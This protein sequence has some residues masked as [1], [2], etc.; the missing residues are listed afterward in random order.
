LLHKILVF[1]SVKNTALLSGIK[2]PLSFAIF[3]SKAPKAFE[4]L[5]E[6]RAAGTASKCLK[7]Q[8]MEAASAGNDTFIKRLAED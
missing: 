4:G 2:I 3:F 8:R 1:Y 6:K 5:L 7:H